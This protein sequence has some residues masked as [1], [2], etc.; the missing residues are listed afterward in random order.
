MRRRRRCPRR[1]PP[2]GVAPS[3]RSAEEGRLDWIWLD[4]TG[5]NISSPAEVLVRPFHV[6][7]PNRPHQGGDAPGSKVLTNSPHPAVQAAYQRAGSSRVVAPDLQSSDGRDAHVE[8]HVSE[9]K[10]PWFPQ[11]ELQVIHVIHVIHIY[12]YIYTLFFV[13]LEPVCL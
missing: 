12:I 11:E 9:G 4:L 2:R 1:H 10:A 5:S 3:R 6:G 7:E 13:V 8:W